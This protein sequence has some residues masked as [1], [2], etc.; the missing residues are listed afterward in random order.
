MPNINH[1]SMIRALINYDVFM[2]DIFS[3]VILVWLLM[4]KKYIHHYT[5][6]LYSKLC[7]VAHLLPQG[8]LR[9]EHLQLGV[10]H[11]LMPSVILCFDFLITGSASGS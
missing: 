7:W 8:Y 3:S 5:K 9:S 10:W 2:D 6:L 4:L 1:A 11:D